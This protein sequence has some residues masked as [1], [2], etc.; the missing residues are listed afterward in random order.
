[1][2]PVFLQVGQTFRAARRGLRH[3]LCFQ[4]PFMSDKAPVLSIQEQG[5]K[6]PMCVHDACV[7]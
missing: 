7:F 2:T 3:V 1:M 5:N 4:P 6:Q